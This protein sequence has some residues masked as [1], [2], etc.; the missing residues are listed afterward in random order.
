MKQPFRMGTKNRITAAGALLL[1]AALLAG[2]SAT[3][4]PKQ[5]AAAEQSQIKTVKTAKIEKRTIDDPAE[6]VADVASSTRMTV[7][8]K[9]GGEVLEVLKKRGDTVEKGELL[10]RIDPKDVLL[11]K[12]KALVSIN[13][14]QQ[15]LSKAVQDLADGKRDLQNGIAKLEQSVRDA[16]KN[17]N[18]MRNDYDQGLVSKI[19][20]EQLETQLNGLR[21]DLESSRGKLKTMESTNSLSQLE[22][23]L[24]TAR[25]SI[26]EIDRTLENLEVRAPVGGVLTDFAVEA[27]MTVPAGFSA[28]DIQRIDP[29][30]VVAELTEDA[31]KLIR[32][33]QELH[34]VIPGS[35]EKLKG[36]VAYLADVMSAQTKSYSLELE[37][38]NPERK[39]KPGMKVQI[40]LN[41]E[42]DQV[43]VT[44]PTTSV[45]REGGETFVYVLNGNVAEKRKVELGRLKDT[46][47]EAI[48]GVKEGE[49]VIVSGQNLLKDKETVQQANP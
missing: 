29:V 19:Q 8:T 44:V 32:G 34:I 35:T 49:R 46:F 1:G 45:I 28:G 17:Y 26:E 40:M 11:Q 38:Q 23:G 18:K 48:S 33:K 14:T 25:L 21:L 42:A 4:E 12:E 7:A 2:C 6:H 10:F 20:L 39:L 27:G 22:Q 13:G 43:V 9:A 41:E 5:A 24:Q 3:P 31:A 37:V 47:Q 16:E 15:Q 30:K 36:S